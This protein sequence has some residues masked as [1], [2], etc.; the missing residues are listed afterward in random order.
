MKSVGLCTHF[1]Q[2][3]EWAFD[4]ALKLAQTR[5]AR[6]NICHW[7]ESPY[8]IRRDIVYADLFQ[9]TETVNVT[10]ELLNRLELQLREYYEPRLGDFTEVAFKLC[11]GAYQVE[12]VR[13]FRQHLLDLVVM[14]Y[15]F[16]SEQ[17]LPEEPPM[18]EFAAAIQYPI[19][20]VGLDGPGNFLL[21]QRAFDML[22][23]LAL[24]EGSWRLIQPALK[25]AL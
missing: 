5:G 23:R 17:A 9:P 22:D 16:P 7:L 25:M 11:E 6:L 8:K 3:D 15:Q 4:Y 13:C 24:E 20:L 12:L 18:E 19:V 14:G 1:M 2:T 21:N 10:P